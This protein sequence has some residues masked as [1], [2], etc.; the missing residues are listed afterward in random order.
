MRPA[1]IV[2]WPQ[3]ICYHVLNGVH[4]GNRGRILAR[5]DLGALIWFPGHEALRA[6]PGTLKLF[7]VAGAWR[8]LS[9]G[10]MRLSKL[11]PSQFAEIDDTLGAAFGYF[12]D[13]NATAISGKPS[14]L[15]VIEEKIAEP[16]LSIERAQIKE[17]INADLP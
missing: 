15:R 4:H 13:K 3:E 8:L 12:L 14:W 9:A 6:D 1:V 7:T 11:T 10:D 16:V 17:F 2:A 5:S